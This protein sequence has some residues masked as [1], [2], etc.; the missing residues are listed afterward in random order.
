[1]EEEEEGLGIYICHSHSVTGENK[2]ISL[3]EN[4]V[5]NFKYRIISNNCTKKDLWES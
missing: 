1:V 5:P 3:R 2:K 4:L